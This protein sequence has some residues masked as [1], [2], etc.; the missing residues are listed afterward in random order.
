MRGRSDGVDVGE[1]QIELGQGEPERENTGV[2]ERLGR[3]SESVVTL[4]VEENGPAPQCC[5]LSTNASAELPGRCTTTATGRLFMPRDGANIGLM[6]SVG[7]RCPPR[8][9]Y[10]E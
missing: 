10:C 7:P 8:P 4:G 6:P 5:S 2:G 1:R 3:R 9:A